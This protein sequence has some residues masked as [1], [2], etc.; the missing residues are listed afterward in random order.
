MRRA[1]T[2]RRHPLLYL[3]DAACTLVAIVGIIFLIGLG[4]IGWIILIVLAIVGQRR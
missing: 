1:D 4:P 3:W 2:R